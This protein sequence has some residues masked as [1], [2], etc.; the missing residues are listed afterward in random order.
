MLI[1]IIVEQKTFNSDIFRKTQSF[2]RVHVSS[3]YT[4]N[5]FGQVEIVDHSF[6]CYYA[7]YYKTIF[8]YY[9]KENYLHLS[10]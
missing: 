8:T 4:G 9:S 2:Q 10:K 5:T 3:E 6:D 7:N 1:F